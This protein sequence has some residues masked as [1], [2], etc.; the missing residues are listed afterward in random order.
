MEHTGNNNVS[1][2]SEKT[3]N[4]LPAEILQ[5]IFSYCSVTDYVDSFVF[6]CKRW[7]QIL[8]EDVLLWKDKWFVWKDE[9]K[10]IDM[11]QITT[12]CPN[13]KSFKLFARSGLYLP[14]L[15]SIQ[16][17]VHKL[18]VQGPCLG[19]FRSVIQF[20]IDNCPQLEHLR[21]SC[22]RFENYNIFS[23]F[24][25]LKVLILEGC[26]NFS[27]CHLR[28]IADGCK[29]LSSISVPNCMDML[30]SDVAYFIKSKKT[31][32]EVLE[33]DGFGLNGS[34]FDD[35]SECL[36]LYKL[37]I[38]NASTMTVGMLGSII[39]LPSLKFLRMMM[40]FLNLKDFVTVWRK[41]GPCNNLI[42]L[43]LEFYHYFNPSM[44]SVIMERCPK[45]KRIIYMRKNHVPLHARLI[46]GTK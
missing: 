23:R 35:I 46:R 41:G 1:S 36:H 12:N 19:S 20:L 4:D 16:E 13:L 17:N 42:E 5:E 32:L 25:K 45:I 34:A 15:E 26:L 37:S 6:V 27:G 30:D 18:E 40:C 2:P 11:R 33:L 24:E 21:F 8:D 29:G 28:A 9:D 3:I 39:N 10:N 14:V 7:K 22:V 31:F 43:D 44:I 38:N